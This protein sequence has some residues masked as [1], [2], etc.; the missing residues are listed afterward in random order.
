LKEEI[1]SADEKLETKNQRK[2]IKGTKT[3]NL[4]IYKNK[5]IFNA[6]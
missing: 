4:Y 6:K 5:I 3:K 1:K 2:I